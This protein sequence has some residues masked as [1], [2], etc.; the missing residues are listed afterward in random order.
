MFNI[1]AQAGVR[2]TFES[3]SLQRFCGAFFSKTV[4]SS[5]ENFIFAKSYSRSSFS[6]YPHCGVYLHSWSTFGIDENVLQISSSDFHPARQNLLIRHPQ[7]LTIGISTMGF[8]VHVIIPTNYAHSV[9]QK[10][11]FLSQ[12]RRT[13]PIASLLGCPICI[14]PHGNDH[15]CGADQSFLPTS[16]LDHSFN[17]F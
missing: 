16:V 13:R 4:R 7:T 1:L 11:M 2:V 8:Q 17:N 12:S 3:K 6:Q 14:Y 10:I 9:L 15:P 5:T